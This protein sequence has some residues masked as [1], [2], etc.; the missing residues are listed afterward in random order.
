MSRGTM[1]EAVIIILI[2]FVI[3]PFGLVAL[4]YPAEPYRQVAGEPV[5]D[6]ALASGVHVVNATDI[7]WELPGAMGGTTYTIADDAGDI[8]H[9]QTQKFDSALSRDGAVV[10]FNAQ[11]V[12]KG[13]PIGTLVI[14]GDNIIHITPDSGGILA[15]LGP[16]LRK[17]KSS[18][19][20]QTLSGQRVVAVVLPFSCNRGPW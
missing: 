11:S 14:I 18:G 17:I 9:V 6:A 12:G 15:R 13:K 7:T 5:R 8:L 2:I 16:E 10:V 4:A 20:G 19:S 3:I 1:E